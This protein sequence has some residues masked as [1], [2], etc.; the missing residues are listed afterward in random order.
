LDHKDLVKSAI[1]KDE[2]AYEPTRTFDEMPVVDRLKSALAAKG[3]THP[4]EIQDKTIEHLLAGKDL[5]GIAKTGTGK[6]AA[7]LVPIIHRLLTGRPFHTLVMVPTREL[8]LQVYDEFQS[9]SKGLPLHGACFIGGT[10]LTKD[11]QK[12]KRQNHI[13]IGTPGRLN[14]L[15]KRRAL[16]MTQFSVLVLDEFDRMLD[17][18]FSPDVM[19]LANAMVNRNQT[20]LFSATIDK[21]QARLVGELTNNPVEIKV[22]TGNVAADHIDQDVIK[23]PP[24]ETKM[25]VLV[26]MLAEPGFEKVLLFADTKRMVQRLNRDLNKAGVAVDEIHGDKSQA[27]RK[28]ALERFREGHVRVLVATDVAAR[29][30]DISDVSHVINFQVPKDYQ[31][32][33][34]RIG[35]T[36]RA[37]KSGKALTF[38]S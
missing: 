32:Y 33:V 30:L 17:M 38:V 35:R 24:G 22:S 16:D 9:F 21:T 6:T 31:S 15:A 28:K 34:H 10:G 26:R 11:I 29:G 2:A 36:G 12:A 27:L 37:G 5:I 3:Y 8:A 20:A 13:V 1:S 25:S 14:D 4:T 23:V 7:F 18:G 19:R